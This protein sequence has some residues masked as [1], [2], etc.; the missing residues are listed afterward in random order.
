MMESPNKTARWTALALGAM[1]MLWLAAP[2][3][4]AQP[5]DDEFL[6]NTYT[7]NKQLYPS[8]GRDG[9]GGCT[10]VWHSHAQIINRDIF[11]QR[12]D[13]EG[14]PIG[15]ETLVNT[16]TDD[17][18]MFAGYGMNRFGD[19]IAVW[20]SNG[21]D[22][23]GSGGTA[24][25]VFA[26]RYDMNGNGLGGEFQVNT[27][28][29]DLGFQNE[30]DMADDLTSVV[31]W[32]SDGDR[33]GSGNA[34]LARIFDPAGAPIGAE[35]IVNE[36]TPG[37]QRFGRVAMRASGDFVVTWQDLEG[38]DGSGSGIW[39]R[40]YDALG[41][42]LSGEFGLASDPAGDQSVPRIDMTPAGEFN[43][44]WST[45]TAPGQANVYLRRFDPTGTALDPEVLVNTTTDGVQSFEDLA[46]DPEGNTVVIW[47]AD[48]QDGGQDGLY[49]QRYDSEGQTYCGELQVNQSA[50][51]EE[52]GSARVDA[53]AQ[54]FTVTWTG[55][56]EDNLG[57]YARRFG[58]IADLAPPMACYAANCV[59][60]EFG[61]GNG[62]GKISAKGALAL[63]GCPEDPDRLEPPL[64]DESM[65]EMLIDGTVVFS[66]PLGSFGQR[67]NQYKFRGDAGGLQF[68]LDR[69]SWKFVDRRSDIQES[70]VDMDDGLDFELRIA[71]H[72]GTENLD[73]V[74]E[75]GKA[76][77]C[78][79]GRS[80]L[81]CI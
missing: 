29:D 56:D 9:S 69:G 58:P 11:L 59:K 13:A 52:D 20:Q 43:V 50:L 25:G 63:A 81:E 42:P 7:T 4:G 8:V 2:P 16:Y 26:Q 10:I 51:P 37:N 6:V 72:T 28:D 60:V 49:L 31:V 27:P 70:D 73:V 46:V 75:R 48:G 78:R 39:G 1:A 77:A 32:T 71:G 3:A 79:H 54:G 47:V 67:G 40:R 5:L 19:S 62:D 57:V 45:S 22:L 34:V 17:H 80:V 12:Y 15:D 38:Q 23:P 35:F 21:Q 55:F 74:F 33:D 68:D 44:G 14:N 76:Q 41:N 61:T 64:E 65:V 24:W 18:Q 36:T 30:A 66:E 53:D